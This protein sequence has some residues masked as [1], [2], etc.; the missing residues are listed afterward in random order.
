MESF[1][2]VFVIFIICM[3]L[4]FDFSSI[5]GV[6]IAVLIGLLL[7]WVIGSL[8]DKAD[9]DGGKV[10]CWL[11]GIIIIV[12]VFFIIVNLANSMSCTLYDVCVSIF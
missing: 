6:I 11:V 2:V 5:L 1:G 3:I 4:G 8:S 12:I 10:G 9:T 7:L